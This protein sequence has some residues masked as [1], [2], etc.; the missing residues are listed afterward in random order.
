VCLAVHYE[1]LVLH[2]EAQMRRILKFLDIPWDENVLHHEQT[3]GKEGG[4]SLSK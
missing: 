1:Q 3:I 4:I 2:P